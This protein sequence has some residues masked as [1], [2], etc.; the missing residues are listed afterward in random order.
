M[1]AWIW[2]LNNVIFTKLWQLNGVQLLLMCVDELII[3]YDAFI[4]FF[5]DKPFICWVLL[6][7]IVHQLL[8]KVFINR[9]SVIHRLSLNWESWSII[10]IALRVERRVGLIKR[11]Y[12]WLMIL[13]A[14]VFLEWA[15]VYEIQFAYLLISFVGI[16]E[17]WLMLRMNRRG[18]LRYGLWLLLM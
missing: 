17:I 6:Q 10:E 2:Y 13:A 14:K 3:Y 7:K 16:N 11:N 4:S 8:V 9:C 1:C 18:K 15:K 12:I 5:V